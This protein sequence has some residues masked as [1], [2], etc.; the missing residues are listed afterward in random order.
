MVQCTLVL[1]FHN[2]SG[3]DVYD[4]VQLE[5]TTLPPICFP[6]MS[7]PTYLHP[8]CSLLHILQN[9]P[10]TK[11]TSLTLLITTLHLPQCNPTLSWPPLSQ[12]ILSAFSTERSKHF[13]SV[14][15]PERQSFLWHHKILMTDRAISPFFALTEAL[16]I[17][18]LVCT[19]HVLLFLHLAQRHNVTRVSLDRYNR[20]AS[21]Q[22]SAAHQLMLLQQLMQLMQLTHYDAFHF[23]RST[24][25]T[26]CSLPT[27]PYPNTTN[28]DA[29]R[30]ATLGNNRPV[31]G[32]FW[33]MRRERAAC[34]APGRLVEVLP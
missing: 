7:D 28:V 29:M 18:V 8:P 32:R 34:I 5:P 16:Y 21:M 1:D 3:F 15:A 12:P 17:I 27:S 11:K 10:P 23:P 13:C 33:F 31:S 22:R 9:F 14:P 26:F 6:R 24:I 19:S 20:I 4:D 30:W 2:E 25:C